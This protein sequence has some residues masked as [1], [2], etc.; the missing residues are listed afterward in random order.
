MQHAARMRR[1]INA[2]EIRTSPKRHLQIISPY[3]ETPLLGYHQRRPMGLYL[4]SLRPYLLWRATHFRTPTEYIAPFTKSISP[5]PYCSPLLHISI[6]PY[7]H[8]HMKVHSVFP[9]AH[10]SH[11]HTFIPICSYLHL[12]HIS[13][14]TK[15]HP[16]GIAYTSTL[17]SI[18]RKTYL[19]SVSAHSVG[20]SVRMDT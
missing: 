5:S 1:V 7:L 10:I 20:N 13:P 19:P 4:H 15:C 9:Y 3:R 17:P 16:N 6:C 11:S 12:L 14:F 2:T 8:A 18:Q